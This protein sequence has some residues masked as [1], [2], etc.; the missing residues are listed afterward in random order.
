MGSHN[1]KSNMN[2]IHTIEL[3]T[4]N[5]FE[6]LHLIGRGGFSKVWKVKWKKTG[7]IF[8][9]KEMSKPRIIDKK[10]EST[11]LLE[12]DLLSK[13]NHPFIVNMHFSFQDINSLY[14]VM[15]LI[16]GKDLRYHLSQKKKFSS[17]IS[18]FFLACTILGLEYIHYNNILHRDI[19]PDNLVIDKNGYVKITDFG[20]SREIGKLIKGES[21]GTPGYMAPEVMCGKSHSIDSDYY[22]L[23]IMA[24][25]FMKGVRPFMC[26]SNAELKKKV[27]ESDVVIN[28]LE[29]PEG[30]GIEAGDFINRLI[31]RK[32]NER[33]G[34]GGDNE[35]KNHLWFKG[36]RWDKL[37]RME[38]KSP[39][40]PPEEEIENNIYIPPID[41]E[42]MKRYKKI[43]NTKEYKIAFKN[44]LFFNLYDKNLNHEKY[45]N[46]HEVYEAQLIFKNKEKNKI[47][48]NIECDKDENI[49]K[50]KE[51]MKSFNQ[52]IKNKLNYMDIFH[53]KNY[54]YDFFEKSQNIP[55]INKYLKNDL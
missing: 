38:L 4:R 25:E 44:F 11:I 12:R 50:E 42:Q 31:K 43:M 37:Y 54:D 45:K 7:A 33:L 52:P 28:K 24:Y 10:C 3:V 40:I 23:G 6:F 32:Q 46:P 39:F 22:C 41:N 34:H 2:V 36:F 30:W 47:N 14:L 9:L 53:R 20:I 35:V 15:D 17:E 51:K 49:K 29:L 18:K 8:A 19:K 16:T 26:K 5:S 27:M 48:N 21:S 1:P 55:N 13:M